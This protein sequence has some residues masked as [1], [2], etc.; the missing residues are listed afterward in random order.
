MAILPQLK[1]FDWH[2]MQPL[3]DLERLRL[4]LESMPDEELMRVLHCHRAKG[5]NDYPVRDVE[6][7]AGRH[8]I[9][10]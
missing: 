9:S 4:A 6:L 5:R 3:G 7:R 2:E 8:C 10:T 1:L